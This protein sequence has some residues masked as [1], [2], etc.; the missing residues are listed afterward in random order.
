MTDSELQLYLK[1][2]P[3]FSEHFNQNK[4][5]LLA[6]IFGVFTINTPFMK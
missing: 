1:K 5:S 4:N 6:K 3:E 2:L